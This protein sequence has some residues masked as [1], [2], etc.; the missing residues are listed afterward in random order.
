MS[1]FTDLAGQ[2]I[3]GAWRSGSGSRDIV[4]VNPYN[5]DKLAAITVAT[6][7]DVDLAYRSA[8]RAQR[9]WDCRRR[10]VSLDSLLGRPSY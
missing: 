9:E 5:G 2:Y 6:A 1:Y 3:D 10:I 4:D 8:E 7:G